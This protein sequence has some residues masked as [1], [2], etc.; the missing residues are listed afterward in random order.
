[1]KMIEDKELKKKIGLQ[2]RDIDKIRKEEYYQKLCEL[3]QELIDIEN[4]YEKVIF[5]REEYNLD[6]KKNI[7]EKDDYNKYLEET[8]KSVEEK[9]KTRE[10]DII[11]IRKNFGF[12]V[13]NKILKL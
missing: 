6:L 3:Q 9:L 8:I 1:M 7:K 11:K 5:E 4:N 13:V 2:L 10:E 12:R